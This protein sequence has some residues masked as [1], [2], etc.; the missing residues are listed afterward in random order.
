MRFFTVA[1]GRAARRSAGWA[2]CLI[3]LFFCLNIIIGYGALVLLAPESR[4]HDAT[5]KLLGGGNMAAL[6][7]ASLLGGNWLQ[8]LIAGVAFATILAVVAGLAIS[9]ASTISHDLYALWLCHGQADPKR[10]GSCHAY[11]P[12]CWAW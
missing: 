1:D 10:N 4:F 12:C 7:L 3:S 5:G 9:G 8:A 6:H 11:P 2:T